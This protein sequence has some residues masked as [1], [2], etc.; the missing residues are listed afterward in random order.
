MAIKLKR[1][2]KKTE[3]R[4][5]T[6]EKDIAPDNT[7]NV[8]RS[9]YIRKDLRIVCFILAC[10][11]SCTALF[12]SEY[13]KNNQDLEGLE[14]SD[15]LYTV[16]TDNTY[17]EMLTNTY[18]QL[19]ILGVTS[20][21][22]MDED[23]EYKGNKYLMDDL[24]YYFDYNEYKYKKT[25]SGILPVTENF[26]YYVSYTVTDDETT[27]EETSDGHEDVSKNNVRYVTNISEN[28]INS[29]MTEDERLDVLRS[30]FSN[31]LLRINDTMTSDMVSSNNSV[32]YEYR[33]ADCANTSD[34]NGLGNVIEKYPSNYLPLGGWYHDSYGRYIYYFGNYDPIKFFIYPE[35]SGQGMRARIE[36]KK[37]TE[38]KRRFNPYEYDNEFSDDYDD[39]Y[40]YNNS[41]NAIYIESMDD[42]EAY[43][44]STEGLTVFIAPKENIIN[45]YEEELSNRMSMLVISGLI[46]KIT[47]IQAI[48]LILLLLYSSVRQGME[49]AI[50]IRAAEIIPFEILAL[51]MFISM[52][53]LPG[54][55]I[56]EVDFATVLILLIFIALFLFSLLNIIKRCFGRR[57]FVTSLL[58]VILKKYSTTD[59]FKERRKINL[60]RR[61]L[62][63][64][65]I[66]LIFFSL[67]CV[68][69]LLTAL[70]DADNYIISIGLI[71]SI[72]IA[73]VFSLG[74]CIINLVN[75][76]QLVK[77]EKRIEAL[78]DR[79]E[80][81]GTVS[82]FSPVSLDMERLGSISD[83]V[84]KAV[85]E[86]IKS[87][88]M[89]IELIANV[90]HDL[91]T[92]LTSII[93]YI[94]LLKKLELDDE[95]AGYVQI[96]DKKSQKLKSIVADVFSLAKA[97][98][99]IDVNMSRI[100]MVM[101]FNQYMADAEDKLQ[102]CGRSFRTTLSV[103]TAMIMADGNK[104]YRVFQNLVDNAVKYSMENSR[105]FL[106]IA[107]QDDKAV[108][109]V[110]N[111]SSYPI[112][113]SADEIT[114]RFVRG[115]RSRTD[116][117]SGLGL[118][119]AKTFT[120]AC[121]GKFD[122][123]LDGDMFKAVVAMPLAENDDRTDDD[124][125]SSGLSDG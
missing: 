1:S 106:D 100:D 12:A 66:L 113:F 44:G 85:E 68:M 87:E 60:G 117:G 82:E 109:T 112:D 93:S 35:N 91:K 98:S 9:R 65:I 43:Q 51:C 121:G 118:S 46:M 90:S 36:W 22:N 29:S 30:K 52:V 4:D 42:Y 125:D 54:I 37:D 28:M 79:N 72:I 111:I 24:L 55:N 115:D 45:I 114:E 84:D 104:L 64:S 58:L 5:I 61:L 103:P 47:G 110:K 78:N 119:I 27:D 89:K 13:V 14:N 107:V 99:G 63:R 38:N 8:K 39:A 108:F 116:G 31:Y 88:R 18:E 97:T 2:S 41:N 21:A 102:N 122:I 20:L 59:L 25:D 32:S 81:N 96:I 123:I 11:F 16:V 23:M 19:C 94:D 69:T 71:V 56:Y 40:Y 83:S 33:D 77:L 101:L 6:D 15:K 92:P 49:K 80:F 105:I 75:A 53:V 120:E 26:D 73:S 86:Q 67:V 17:K 70:F 48:L 95:A 7:N 62:T 74:I 124:T 50:D 34:N 57:V 10:V 76:T 3:Q